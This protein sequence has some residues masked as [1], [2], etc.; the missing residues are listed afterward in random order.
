LFSLVDVGSKS[1]RASGGN[2]TLGRHRVG[3]ID[4]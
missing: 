3:L 2:T 4:R 1:S